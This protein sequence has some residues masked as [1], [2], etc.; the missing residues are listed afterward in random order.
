MKKKINLLVIHKDCP[1]WI[2]G[3][4]N[5]KE[6]R[7]QQLLWLLERHTDLKECCRYFFGANS[8]QN[9]LNEPIQYCGYCG[10]RLNKK[11][12]RFLNDHFTE[13]YVIQK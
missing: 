12:F 5:K 7:W 1:K 11:D 8:L 3:L 2:K 13:L 9:I 4:N 10:R 6:I